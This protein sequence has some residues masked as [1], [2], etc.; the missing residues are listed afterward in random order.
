MKHYGTEYLET[1]RL[2]LRKFV[3]DDAKSMYENWA[4][5][6]KVTKYLT[7]QAHNDISVSQ[8]V[9]KEWISSYKNQ[10]FYQWAIILK[11]NGLN[12]IGSI[13][14]TSYNDIIGMAHVGYCIGQKWWHNGITSEALNC[15]INFL[16]D[17]V[18]V[19][20]IEARHDPRNTNSGLVMK[21]CGME[22]EG[23]LKKADWNNQGICDACYYS[24]LSNA[25]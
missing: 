18:G 20:R 3:L 9:L 11:E 17:K 24:V 13:G 25:R 2:I 7:W 15:V 10:D 4:S 19:Q 16:F 5:D 1:N 12:P 8:A 23:T 6:E 14:I 21:K 22:Y